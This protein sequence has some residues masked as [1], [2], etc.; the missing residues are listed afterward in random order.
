MRYDHLLSTTEFRCKS[1]ILF[2]DI[3]LALV[4]VTS[5]AASGQSIELTLASQSQPNTAVP[6]SVNISGAIPTTNGTLSAD[7][8]SL[9]GDAA[10][11]L[12]EGQD[13]LL[14][15]LVTS[16]EDSL[17]GHEGHQIA[18]ILPLAPNDLAYSGTITFTATEP[19]ALQVY[20]VYDSDR[21][22]Y[23][24]DQFGQNSSL[25]LKNRIGIMSLLTHDF[26]HSQMFSASIPFTGNTA[27]LYSL[28]GKPFTAAYSMDIKTSRA[29]QTNNTGYN[30]TYPL[31]T[32]SLDGPAVEPQ[33]APTAY[34]TAPSLLVE[35]LT[36]LSPSVIAELPLNSLPEDD[37]L[38]I[39]DSPPEKV[40]KI[41]DK[42]PP[43]KRAEL[44]DK[45]PP[46]KRAE[47]LDKLPPG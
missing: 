4:L 2:L 46:D 34:I 45:L 18:M 30:V 40:T 17:P 16:A 33:Q 41:L 29:V 39:F 23:L 13:I 11:L 20:H 32:S 7:T 37:L 22:A 8:S 25:I 6:T 36:I 19:V 1:A 12:A 38:K 10:E 26:N 47:L 5:L 28:S 21:S 14:H 43:D 27:G 15:G 24:S 31:E 35:A 44:L 42:L 9:H 3:A